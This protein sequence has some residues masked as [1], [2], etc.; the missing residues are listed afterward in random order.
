MKKVKNLKKPCAEGH[1]HANAKKQTE[2]GK[3]PNCTAQ[4]FTQGA[5]S[6]NKRIHTH[7]RNQWLCLLE[8]IIGLSSKVVQEASR[9]LILIISSVVVLYFFATDHISVPFVG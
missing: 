3:R 5:E 7:R 8:I 1:K 4:D 2:H 6:R 9:E